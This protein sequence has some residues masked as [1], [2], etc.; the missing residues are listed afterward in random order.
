MDQEQDNQGEIPLDQRLLEAETAVQ[1]FRLL[2]K[3]P[4]W[5]ELVKIMQA[6]AQ[7]RHAE[8]AMAATMSPG[9]DTVE[10]GGVKHVFPI[11]GMTKVL[12]SEFE[13]GVRMG[14]LMTLSTPVALEQQLS[15]ECKMM[16]AQLEAETEA[17]FGGN[18]E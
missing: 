15:E 4:G 11:D 18:D 12:R 13:K 2:L 7:Q 5:G 14:I 8:V 1:S 6:Q 3:S 16:R 9:Y 17:E 10:V